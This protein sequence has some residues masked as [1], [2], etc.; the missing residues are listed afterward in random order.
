MFCMCCRSKRIFALKLGSFIASSFRYGTMKELTSLALLLT[1]LP[2]L[3]APKALC[4]FHMSPVEVP[5]ELVSGGNVSIGNIQVPACAIQW[6]KWT[7]CHG[8]NNLDIAA[9]Q[10][11]FHFVQVLLCASRKDTAHFLAH[12]I[13]FSAAEFRT[14]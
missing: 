9:L 7:V 10:G 4:Y 13:H 8:R 1:L 12:L 2:T 6:L 11:G 3:D 5:V 14:P